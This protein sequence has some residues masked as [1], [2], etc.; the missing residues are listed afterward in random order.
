MVDFMQRFSS[1]GWRPL[2]GLADKGTDLSPFE[3]VFETYRGNRKG[4]LVFKSVTGGPV[5]VVEHL[6]AQ[7]QR[8]SGP[9]GS[10]T[11]P[12]PYWTTF[13]SS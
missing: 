5:N 2:Q 3:E 7:V 6:N 9:R 12:P 8:P 1:L 4:K 13:P 10:Q 11:T